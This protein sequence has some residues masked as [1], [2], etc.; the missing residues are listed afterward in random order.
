MWKI[1][2]QQDIDSHGVCDEYSQLLHRSESEDKALAL[3]KRGIDWC[4]EHDSPSLALL[5][6]YKTVCELNGVYLDCVFNG[7]LLDDEMVYVFHNC[8]GTINIDLNVE[9]AIIP[10]LYFANG[11]EMTVKRLA[12][13]NIGKIEVPLYIFGANKIT[14]ENTDFVKFNIYYDKGQTANR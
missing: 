7:D 12:E 4:L 3:Y 10:M 2:A 9:K 11:C 6:K 5:R 14:T 1:E 13:S 8:K